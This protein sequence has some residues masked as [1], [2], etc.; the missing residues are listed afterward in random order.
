MD[1]DPEGFAGPSGAQ[2]LQSFEDIAKEFDQKIDKGK[3]DT[4]SSQDPNVQEEPELNVTS[5][6]DQYEGN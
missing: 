2:P 5:P 6:L 4:V 1:F 3:G